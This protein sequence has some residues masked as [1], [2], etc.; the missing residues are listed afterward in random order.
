MNLCYE[1]NHSGK[2]GL[3]CKHWQLLE[4]SVVMDVEFTIRQK[5]H[6]E[7]CHKCQQKYKLY[8]TK[9]DVVRSYVPHVTPD[10]STLN[11][12]ENEI[13]DIVLKIY[14][15]DLESKLYKFS[16]TLKVVGESLKIM[17]KSWPL[18]ILSALVVVAFA[19]NSVIC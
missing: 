5:K 16:D 17:S 10:D 18:R 3:E 14:D 2:Q 9:E 6:F 19:V 11:F 1:F 15:K 7:Q 4:S 8:K 12:L 13:Q